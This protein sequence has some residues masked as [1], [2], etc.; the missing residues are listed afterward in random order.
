MASTATPAKNQTS[1]LDAE[2]LI[3]G[4]G[5]GGM[6]AA[7]ELK[8]LGFDS[9]LMLDRNDDLGGTWHVNRYPGLAV[10]IPSTTYSYSFEP[11]PWW[12]RLY[13]PGRELKKYAEHV[14]DKYDLRRHMRHNVTVESAK[15]DEQAQL[16]TVKLADGKPLT[17]RYLVLATGFLSQPK[18]PD[19][20]GIDDFAGKIIHTA[21]WDHD[22]DL[23]GKHAAVIGTGATAVQLLPQIAPELAQ[24]DVYQ[25]TP[26]WVTPKMDGP[27]PGILRRLFAGV[28]LTQRSA[29]AV[30]DKVLEAIMVNGV[31]DA[32]RINVLNRGIEAFCKAH[33]RRQVRDP[34]TRRKLTPQ[35]SFGCKRP[36]FSN[37]YYPTFNRDNVELITNGIERIEADG[38]VTSDGRK[39][40]IDTLILATGF[41]LWEEN[42]PAFQVVGRK[43]RNLGGWW[44]ETRFQSY[45]GITMPGFP[46]LFSVPTPYGYN[47]LSFFSTIEAQMKHMARCIEEMRRRE[48][49]TFEVTD[50][51]CEA[52]TEDMRRRVDGSVFVRG[53]CAGSRSYY[54]N[55]HGEAVL[56]RPTSTSESMRQAESFDLN[57]YVFA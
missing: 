34:E 25:R 30:S 17:A 44:R 9:L 54:F 53:N 14:A 18:K 13:A 15:F 57:S 38:V 52:F 11:N 4:T 5:F 20:E 12:S 45:E 2:A 36:T 55:P 40:K 35:Y 46:N 47:G 21:E 31:V 29:R 8:R 39:R 10:D 1:K 27:I 23:T 26:I 51:A 24:L 16:W 50:A 49:T 43:G 22:Y 3:V 19:I 33:L 37:S 32:S 28:P 7:I 42:F 41:S 48:A 6:G 56:L